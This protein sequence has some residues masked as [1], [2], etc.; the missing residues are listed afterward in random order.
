M[1]LRSA[2]LGGLV[3]TL[4]DGLIKGVNSIFQALINPIVDFLQNTIWRGIAGYIYTILVTPILLC[5]DIVNLLFR[6]F[7]GL[8]SYYDKSIG[9]TVQGDFV[10]SLITSKAIMN[11]FWAMVILGVILLI[12]CTF[13]AVIKS[14]FTPMGDKN[15]GN[16]KW[17][18]ISTAV[19]SLVNMAVVPI[20]ALVGIM[21]GNALLN[22]LDQATN[23]ESAPISGRVFVSSAYNCNVV[24]MAINGEITKTTNNWGNYDFVDE[25]AKNCYGKIFDRLT[26]S[27]KESMAESIDNVFASC[28]TYDSWMK[29]SLVFKGIVGDEASFYDIDEI[30]CFY[31]VGYFNFIIFLIVAV[32]IGTMLIMIM[33]GL[34]KRVFTL[35]TLF[36]IA[37]PILAV[38]PI[39][40]DGLKGWNKSFIKHTLSAYSSVVCMNLFLI[41]I[42][43]FNNI[44]FFKGDTIGG[45]TGSS[46]LTGLGDEF[47]K[48]FI[49]IGGLVFVKDL[50]KEIAGLI[51]SESAFAEGT[52]K[53]KDMAAAA[54]KIAG[55]V[56]TGGALAATSL[57]AVPGVG[58]AVN[59]VKGLGTKLSTKI[60]NVKDSAV[61]NSKISQ[62]DALQEKIK[63]RTDNGKQATASQLRQLNALNS[64]IKER[65]NSI[66]GRNKVQEAK[67]SSLAEDSSKTLSERMADVKDSAKSFAGTYVNDTVGADNIE[68]FQ[69]TKKKVSK[70]GGV[71]KSKADAADK[72]KSKKERAEL[73][74]AIDNAGKS[75]GTNVAEKEAF[76][77]EKEAL[78]KENQAYKEKEK[79]VT[80]KRD[81]DHTK[82]VEAAKKGWVT[83][84]NNQQKYKAHNNSNEELVDVVTKGG[85]VIKQPKSI[86]QLR[87]MKRGR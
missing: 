39:Y 33:I 30:Y 50:T 17:K 60:G 46:S 40:P 22:S 45:K 61:M 2:Q 34:I 20:C 64:G 1:F 53:A 73:L 67:L 85:V 28:S 43:A 37:P 86:A 56:A 12:I 38:S 42:R 23:L 65:E 68:A 58:K 47:A 79:I 83:R 9:S 13:I 31:N 52:D 3:K 84:K 11:V 4:I 41:I 5:I 8:S 54:G 57:K 62:R 25:L 74:K 72:A 36:V 44:S 76:M 18:I 35:V 7:A 59:G 48:M 80:Q 10:Y 75:V 14:E 24:R 16:N 66:A 6:K 71:F 32:V 63:A 29:D 49:I 78:V 26:D 55:A 51:G 19:R 27:Q 69:G 15:G 87:G 81:L 21:I 82:R 70:K 77:K